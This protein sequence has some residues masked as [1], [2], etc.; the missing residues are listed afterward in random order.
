MSCKFI[1]DGCKKENSGIYSS[2]SWYKPTTWYERSD[3]DGVQTAC[4]QECIE[5]ISNQTGKTK[6]VMPF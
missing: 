6:V 2:G 4:S 5:K 3:G 1:C